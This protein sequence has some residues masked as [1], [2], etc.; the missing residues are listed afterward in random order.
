MINGRPIRILALPQAA[1]LLA[2][3][4]GA[5]SAISLQQAFEDAGPA[6][7]YAKWV[8]LETGIVYTG[9]LQIG[10]S[11]SPIKG[12]L[13]GPPGMDVRIVGDGAILDLQG[14]QLCISYCRNKLD[15]DDCIVLNGNIRFRGISTADTIALPRGSVRY[16]TFYRTHDYGI[17]LQGAGDGILLERNLVVTAFDTGWDFIY[18]HGTSNSWLPTGACVSFSAQ[19]GWY[20]FP[21]IRNNWTFQEDPIANADPLRQYSQLCEYG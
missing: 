1:L 5:S 10:P 20:G 21:T 9:G 18:T 12:A 11:L 13:T 14:S 15:I 4:I 8:Q 6:N 16:V 3:W 7:G 19:Y 2:L 17:R